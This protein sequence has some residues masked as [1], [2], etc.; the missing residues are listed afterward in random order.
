VPVALIDSYKPFEL[1]S[2]RPVRTKVVFLKPLYYEEYKNMNSKDIAIFVR[3]QI[4]NAIQN[5]A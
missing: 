3:N 4:V 2:L 5:Y 1:N